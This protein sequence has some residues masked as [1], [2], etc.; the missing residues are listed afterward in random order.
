MKTKLIGFILAVVFLLGIQSS[1]F[2]EAF[3]QVVAASV[4]TNV[5]AVSY[6]QLADSDDF[7]TSFQVWEDSLTYDVVIYLGDPTD[8]TTMY[9]TIPGG[10]KP[11]FAYRV[12]AT[13]D[14]GI[15]VKCTTTADATVNFIGFKKVGK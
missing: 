15:Y 7:Y 8:S 1:S 13:N 14:D 9:F 6:G 10:T 2:A 5:A 11:T 4:N 12:P 3:D